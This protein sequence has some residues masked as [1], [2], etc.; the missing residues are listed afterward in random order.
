MRCIHEGTSQAIFGS[1]QVRTCDGCREV[2]FCDDGGGSDPWEALSTLFGEYELVGRLDTI[3][4]PA[5]EVLAYCSRR[6]AGVAAL[7]VTPPHRWLEVTEHLWMCHDGALLL[8]A[9]RSPGVS[10]MVGA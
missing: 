8:L 2:R 5:G 7:R 3:H 10:R 4:A 1:L 6:P 9:H